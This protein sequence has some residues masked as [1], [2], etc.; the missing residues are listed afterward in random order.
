MTPIP[1][2]TDNLYK[3]VALTGVAVV[4]TSV[5]L[6]ATKLDEIELKQLDTMTQHRVL[7]I[8][9][10]ALKSQVERLSVE[11]TALESSI[12]GTKLDVEALSK[13]AAALKTRGHDLD[14]RRARLEAKHEVLAKTAE[15]LLTKHRDLDARRVL[16]EV[17]QEELAGK[18][19][20]LALLSRKVDQIWWLLLA[21]ECFGLVMGIL[22]FYLWYLRVQVPA[23]VAAR[24]EAE[25]KEHS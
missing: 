16:F 1:L 17:K 19:H 14:A 7:L 6:R 11:S 4:M 24:R 13:P 12:A 2:P 25:P 9:G 20:L 3:F 21:L 15:T 18:G 8:E 5:V 22:G 23:D 10:N